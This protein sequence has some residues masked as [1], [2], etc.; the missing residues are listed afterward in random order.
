MPLISIEHPEFMPRSEVLKAQTWCRRSPLPHPISRLGLLGEDNVPR[1]YALFALVVIIE[2][3]G[4]GLITRSMPQSTALGLIAVALLLDL[5]FAFWHHRQLCPRILEV[6]QYIAD[7]ENP[8]NAKAVADGYTDKISRRNAIGMIPTIFLVVLTVI[9]IYFYYKVGGGRVSTQ[10][11]AMSVLY[12]GTCIVHLRITGYVLSHFWASGWFSLWGFSK[13]LSRYKSN[14]MNEDYL[15]IK[16][17]YPQKIHGD[18]ALKIALTK[19]PNP[20]EG[21]PFG[22]HRSHEIIFKIENEKWHLYLRPLGVIY[23]DD[24]IGLMNLFAESELSP[25]AQTEVAKAALFHQAHII[26]GA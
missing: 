22:K 26:I 10:L 1:D 18:A 13:D 6:K 8:K 16:R 12:I 11:L 20:E 5:F 14:P 19:V 24:I 21:L 15:A 9:K 17:S 2:I 25:A 3:I 7:I 23:D 4:I